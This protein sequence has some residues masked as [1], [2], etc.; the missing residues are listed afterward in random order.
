MTTVY[1][2]G[3]MTGL[4]DLNFPA[5]HAAAATLR[6]QGHEVVNPAEINPDQTMPWLECMRRDLAALVFCEAIY[7][8][9]GWERSNGATLEHHVAKRLGLEIWQA[10][11]TGKDGLQV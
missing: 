7:L 4:S 2:A 9:P 11:A 6:A 8:L 1:I 10:G 3:P 5:F